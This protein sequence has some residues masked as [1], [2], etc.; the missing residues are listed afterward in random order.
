MKKRL[1]SMILVLAM[2]ASMLMG[3]TTGTE[4]SSEG[5]EKTEE[6]SEKKDGGGYTI[7]CTVYY[8]TEFI[9]LMVDGMEEKAK[10]L[11]CD[12]V[13]LDAQN[14]AQNQI[15]QVENLIAQK[16]D[17]IV[18]AAVDSDAIVPAIEM[19]EE[20]NIPLVGVNMLINTD[21]PYHYVGPD[22]VLA[23]ELEMQHAID[24]IGGKGNVVIL[25]GPIGQSAQ[26]QRLEG[27]MNVL[28]K[29][30]GKVELLAQQTA[31]WSREE[32]LS[33]VENWIE[34][35]GGKINAVVAQ[36]DEMALGAIQALEAAGVK[37]KVVVTAVDAIK[38]G[39]NAVKEG[40]LLGTVYQDAALEGQEAVQK[41]YDVLE[42]TVTEKKLDYIDMPW[43]TTEN[44]DDLLTTI[45]AE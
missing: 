15:T 37:D 13:M 28:K 34:T 32:A 30:E 41:A 38:D 21:Q 44:V 9:T 16:V 33:L 22:D 19:C 3:C 10:E 8:M 43:I 45:Y 18:V 23:G 4:S 24:E 29:Y 5:S 36:N 11:G 27:N 14:D 17:I 26:I 1:L 39:C 35:F 31:N 20:A 40:K 7:G 2:A 25:E 12:L 42:G 6:K